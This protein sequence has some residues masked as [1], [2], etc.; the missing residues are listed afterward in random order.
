MENDLDQAMN[1]IEIIKAAGPY[2]VAVAGMAFG[3][4]QSGVT[5]RGVTWTVIVR[6]EPT[7]HPLS[8]EQQSGITMDRVHE[9]VHQVMAH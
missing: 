1:W 5:W 9:I 3:F 7:G 4:F 2:I 6:L 8:L